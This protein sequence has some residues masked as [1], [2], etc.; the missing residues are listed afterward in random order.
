MAPGIKHT[1]T[2]FHS[3]ITLSPGVPVEAT[4]EFVYNKSYVALW[5]RIS[6]TVTVTG[7]G[8]NY[9]AATNPILALIRNIKFQ[10]SSDGIMYN[11]PGVAAYHLAA[12][13]LNKYP[14]IDNGGYAPNT[15]A[16][17]VMSVSI[18]L[19]FCDPRMNRAEDTILDASRYTSMTLAVTIGD[20]SECQAIGVGTGATFAVSA[21]TCDIETETYPGA[22]RASMRPIMFQ[23]IIVEGQPK[24]VASETSATITRASDRLLKRILLVSTNGGVVSKPCGGV[25]SS[26]I[27][28]TINLGDDSENFA[29]LRRDEAVLDEN[30]VE[31]KRLATAGVYILDMVKDRWST[32]AMPTGNKSILKVDYT[33]DGAA[34]ATLTNMV[35]VVTET[36]NKLK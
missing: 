5:L 29:Y 1:E 21:A 27:M 2:K 35:S 4:K 30:E 14:R 36:L 34:P 17:Y 26:A 31:Y 9:V 7:S 32:S 23:Q 24:N 28:E 13:K 6:A 8:S 18:P 3:R 19:L 10:V 22:P 16:A 20:G 15:P 11:V 33:V 25:G 12:A